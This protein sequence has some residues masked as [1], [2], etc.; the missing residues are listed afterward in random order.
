MIDDILQLRQLDFSSLNNKRFDYESQTCIPKERVDLTT[1]C[2][3]H[4][5]FHPDMLVRYMKG[6][7][8]GKERNAKYNIEKAGPCI[9]EEDA[10]HIDRIIT[11]GCPSYIDFEEE[12]ENK[13][14]VLQQGN[15]HTF[16]K[17]PEVTAK[18][19]KKEEKT[20]TSSQ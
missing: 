4:Y 11:Q 10:A 2:F 14:L 12:Y 5:G 8:V 18:A 16:L 17:H 3:I 13:L 20:A 19:M 15:Q 6:E 9:N 1:A 7:Y